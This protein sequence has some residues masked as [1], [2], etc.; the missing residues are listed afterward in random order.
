MTYTESAIRFEGKRTRVRMSHGLAES[1]CPD[2]GGRFARTSGHAFKRAAHEC[3]KAALAAEASGVE[4][5][6]VSMTIWHG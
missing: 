6:S 3:G 5:P 1:S 2:F 4:T